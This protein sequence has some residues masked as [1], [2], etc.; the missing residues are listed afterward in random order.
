MPLQ[1]L[2]V[3]IKSAISWRAMRA[4]YSSQH[5]QDSFRATSNPPLGRRRFAGTSST[6]GKT[7]V[8]PIDLLF[9]LVSGQPDLIRI[10]DHNVI[11]NSPDTVYSSL[12]PC[13][14]IFCAT[15]G[16][17]R[18]NTCPAASRTNHPPP[19][20]ISSVSRPGVHTCACAQSHFPCENKR[21]TIKGIRPFVNAR[22]REFPCL[23]ARP[24]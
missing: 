23:Y 5:S 16:A 22:L 18:P 6:A 3:E 15:R 1:T 7:T 4:T 24:H 12:C 8:V 17:I 11:A 20:S 10:N 13:R 21:K 19:C 14:L 2:I 9:Q